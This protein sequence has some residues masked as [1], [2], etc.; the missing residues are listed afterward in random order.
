[1][2]SALTDLG[3]DRLFVVYAGKGRYPLHRKADAL[4][5][6]DCLRELTR[7]KSNGPPIS[8]LKPL[9]ANRCRPDGILIPFH[10]VQACCDRL[11]PGPI[12]SSHV[13][14]RPCGRDGACYNASN[15]AVLG[16]DQSSAAGR[17]GN[18]I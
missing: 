18:E 12:E 15:E 16:P 2:V 3:L 6:P 9:P 4:S 14:F 7:P 8:M 10:F 1:M 11:V 13:F 5:L 17:R